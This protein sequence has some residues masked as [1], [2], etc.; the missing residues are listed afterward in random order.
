[1]A[2]I[3]F[4][5]LITLALSLY[6]FVTSRDVARLSASVSKLKAQ[7]YG[8][9]DLRKSYNLVLTIIVLVFSLIF[10]AYI[11]YDKIYGFG[12]PVAEKKERSD[13]FMLTLNAPPIE[14]NETLPPAFKLNGKQGSGPQSKASNASEPQEESEE[15][16]PENV[17]IDN[18][19]ENVKVKK[20]NDNPNPE[21]PVKSKSQKSTSSAEQ[22]VKD[23]E[24]KLFEDAKGVKE[25]ERIQK[26]AEEKRKIREQKKQQPQNQS[27]Q[28]TNN[29]GG[30][31]GAKGKTMVNFELKGRTPHNNDLWYVRNPGYTCGQ[32]L[33][34]EVV[35]K[36]K[37]NS[38][39]DVTE[40]TI[41]GDVSGLN[42]CLA[43]QAKD[44]AKKSRFNASDAA[45]QEGK[46][47]YRFVP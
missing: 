15:P 42:P 4:I 44:Y 8:A 5:V 14:H 19:P 31:N 20:T 29:D 16:T 13:T 40:A 37:V 12:R 2:V 39:G 22:E 27:T 28:S 33:S 26:E 6:D 36:I 43:K 23:F 34:G 32:G 21:K 10:A 9:Y 24:R 3:V 35:V 1:M 18:V 41:V 11:S 45:S 30:N 7:K 38:N 47:I 46:I 25:R 17:D